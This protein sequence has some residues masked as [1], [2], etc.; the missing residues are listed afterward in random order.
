[1][2][3]DLTL[4]TILVFI[5]PGVLMFFGLPFDLGPGFHD[6]RS[7][8][9]LPSSETL[10]V[11]LI[12][13]F[14]AGVILDSLRTVTIQLAINRILKIRKFNHEVPS[15]DYFKRIDEKKL[16]VF[17][18]IVEK[19]F[20]Y[21]RLNANLCCGLLL[22]SAMRALECGF[23]RTFLAYFIGFIIWFLIASKSKWDN[24]KILANYFS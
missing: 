22:L 12:V 21:Y 3:F 17:E 13:A 16:P 15:L 18:M 5:A 14:F 20:A 7:F 23:D 4:A 11:I 9:T 2:K 1:M 24:D 8:Q 10:L 19:S 6:L